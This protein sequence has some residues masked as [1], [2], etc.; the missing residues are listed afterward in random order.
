MNSCDCRQI[1]IKRSK[2]V[3]WQYR[4]SAIKKI[5]MSFGA[6]LL[7]KCSLEARFGWQS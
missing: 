3:K 1:G 4:A 6:L 7:K 5:Q 2:R